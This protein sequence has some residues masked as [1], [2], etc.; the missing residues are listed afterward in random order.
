MEKNE[1]RAVIEH[2]YLKRLTPKEIKTK[3]DEVHGTSATAF[4]TIY[5]RVNEFKRRRTS[6]ND[7][8]RS[9]RPEEE[10]SS[11]MIDKI[12]D[13]VL[14][15]RRI[16]VREIGEARGISQGTVFSILHEKL[17]VKKISERRVPCLLLMENKRNRVIN[18]DAGLVLFRRNPD[19]FL[20]R[21][22][23]VDAKWM[24]Y[25]T[26]ET[27][28]QSKQW[29]FKGDSAPKKAKTVKSGGK[30]MATIFWDAHGNIY[31]DYLAKGQTINGEYYA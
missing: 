12:H 10:T 14:S 26:P 7:Q 29:V 28:E 11:E 16:K 19:E 31:V 30:V 24:R 17:G 13:M 22:I 15:D 23:T 8:N 2:F 27:K 4:A 25:Y 21:Y 9:G 3:S 1:F 5:N 18:S 20:R 6:T